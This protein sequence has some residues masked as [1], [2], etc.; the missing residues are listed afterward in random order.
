LDGRFVKE[1]AMLAF[2]EA[3]KSDRLEEFTAEREAGERGSIDCAEFDGA[4]AGKPEQAM[5]NHY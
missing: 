5:S 3:I 4:V 1:S 2:A